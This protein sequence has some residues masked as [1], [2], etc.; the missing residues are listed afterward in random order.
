MLFLRI[1]G[2]R[3]RDTLALWV[4]ALFWLPRRTYYLWRYR[5]KQKAWWALLQKPHRHWLVWPFRLEGRFYRW[6]G[7][8]FW[9]D[10][11]S[12]VW[13]VSRQYQDLRTEWVQ[14][15]LRSGRIG[16]DIGAHHGFW[17]LYHADKFPLQAK[18]I[19]V[20]P[21]PANFAYLVQNLALN[22][23][24]YAVPLP[25]AMWKEPTSLA[26]EMP[27]GLPSF[28]ASYSAAIRQGVSER[29]SSCKV[30]A[31]TIDALV[32]CLGLETV[33]WIKIDAEGAEVA[34]LEGARQTLTRFAPSIW[35]EVHNTWAPVLALLDQ[36]GYAVRD[37]VRLEG[38]DAPYPSY[39]Y[40][41]AEKKGAP[42]VS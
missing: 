34:I 1:R 17:T 16:L 3:R 14:A 6:P 31:T 20:E 18:V 13:F 39:G 35:M 42:S 10:A 27:A 21:H 41:W 30:P 28:H 9:A 15:R 7:V 40:L 23:A 19:L 33:D 38:P 29:A 12:L 8:R 5:D 24:F 37:Q 4:N 26:I 36:L 25:L 11:Q 2:L 22:K 32:S